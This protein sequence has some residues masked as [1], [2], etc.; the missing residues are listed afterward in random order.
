M[1]RY[2]H[3]PTRT[4]YKCRLWCDVGEHGTFW[5]M[6]LSHSLFPISWSCTLNLLIL[7]PQSPKPESQARHHTAC[8]RTPAPAPCTSALK[9]FQSARHSFHTRQLRKGFTT[10]QKIP[11]V[12][13]WLYHD[14]TRILARD[15]F[16]YFCSSS[17]GQDRADDDE[18]DVETST[19]STP[20]TPLTMPSKRAGMIISLG[21]PT[22]SGKGP[23]PSSAFFNLVAEIVRMK[24]RCWHRNFF[25]EWLFFHS[26]LK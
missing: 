16:A 10:T 2:Q 7:I 15:A 18:T 3:E 22:E 21:Q 6:P 19:P 20:S 4:L 25:W 11:I 24:S 26:D 5:H 9:N 1:Y 14:G 8:E 12:Y 13:S 17:T 23:V